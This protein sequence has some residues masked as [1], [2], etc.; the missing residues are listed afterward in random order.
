MGDYGKSFKKEM[1]KNTGKWLSNKVFGDGHATPHKVRIQ[2]EKER[3]AVREHKAYEKEQKSLER[4]YAREQ[5]EEQ[6]RLKREEIEERKALREEAKEQ[7]QADR[8]LKELEKKWAEEEKEEIRKQNEQEVNSFNN[9]LNFVQSAHKITSFDETILNGEYQEEVPIEKLFERELIKNLLTNNNATLIDEILCFIEDESGEEVDLK[10]D[11][12]KKTDFS[13]LAKENVIPCYDDF[14]DFLESLS[15]KMQDTPGFFKIILLSLIEKS[16]D[17]NELSE[18]FYDPINPP[19]GSIRCKREE[20]FSIEG[21]LFQDIIQF[22]KDTLEVLINEDVHN[23]ILEQYNTI[24]DERMKWGESNLVEDYGQ[25][26]KSFLK[27]YLKLKEKL[28]EINYKLS[29]LDGNSIVKLFKKKQITELEVLQKEAKIQIENIEEK[30]LK[31]Q[32][33]IEKEN[34]WDNM[35]KE[36]KAAFEEDCEEI[37][38]YISYIAESTATNVKSFKADE[39]YI[40]GLSS[41]SIEAKIGFIKHFDLLD[42]L[43][44][45]GSTYK[46]ND[47]NGV[48][49]VNLFGEPEIVVP[50][51]KKILNSKKEI[52]I[53]PFSSGE[54]NLILQDYLCS[55]ILRIGREIF[56]GI[57]EE[58]IIINAID[59]VLNP[60]TGNPEDLV[61]F[62]VFIICSNQNILIR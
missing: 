14:D 5:R 16:L 42:F 46:I 26:Y 58:F 40:K 25:D 43:N 51:D 36:N 4:D 45:F 52:V 39:K 62:F 11:N 54:R 19:L 8:E 28:R 12:Y 35:F 20:S 24:L 55:S 30:A 6:N 44:D 29:E 61:V 37:L 27:N 13:V 18:K 48:I 10:L 41:E 57:K 33:A 15:R 23:Q 56:S 59:S 34:F 7:K 50:K 38:E 32:T 17:E 3:D 1:G 53:K 21:Q 2:R 9:Y 60:A 49:E 22:E 31:L 47:D